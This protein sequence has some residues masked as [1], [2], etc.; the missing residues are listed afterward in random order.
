MENNKFPKLS[1][2][3]RINYKGDKVVFKNTLEEERRLMYVAITR[4]KKELFI[5]YPIK[6]ISYTP[7]NT[8]KVSFY[9]QNLCYTEPSCFIQEFPISYIY[10]IEYEKS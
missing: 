5:S 2:S 6:N 10:N 8:K 4:A 1:Q 7:D 9:N 3:Y